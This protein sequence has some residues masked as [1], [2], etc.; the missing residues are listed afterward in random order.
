MHVTEPQSVAQPVLP[1]VYFTAHVRTRDV[2]YLSSHPSLVNHYYQY[3]HVY[4][5]ASYA[6]EHEVAF[7]DYP[8]KLVFD[9]NAS[10]VGERS[11]AGFVASPNS[12]VSQLYPA[13]FTEFGNDS[14]TV[15]TDIPLHVSS[16]FWNGTFLIGGASIKYTYPDG[17]VSKRHPTLSAIAIY[18]T[19]VLT[20]G[21]DN[22]LNLTASVPLQRPFSLSSIPSFKN[23]PSSNMT[24]PTPIRQWDERNIA[25]ASPRNIA[26]PVI[27]KLSSASFDNFS[28]VTAQGLVLSGTVTSVELDMCVLLID[29]ASSDEDVKN[30]AS[31]VFQLGKSI[32]DLSKAYAR[33]TG[34]SEGG[35]EF[36]C[37]NT[38][39]GDVMRAIQG[40][41][42]IIHFVSP[43]ASTWESLTAQVRGF[44]SDVVQVGSDAFATILGAIECASDLAMFPIPLPYP[45]CIGDLVMLGKDAYDVGKLVKD[46]RTLN[47]NFPDPVYSDGLFRGKWTNSWDEL[48]SFTMDVSTQDFYDV[49]GMLLREL[50]VCRDVKNQEILVY[51][52]PCIFANSVK[53]AYSITSDTRL[54]GQICAMAK[55]AGLYPILGNDALSNHKQTSSADL[56]DTYVAQAYMSMFPNRYPWKFALSCNARNSSSQS[57]TLGTQ[58]NSTLSNTM[59]PNGQTISGHDIPGLPTTSFPYTKYQ[60]IASN[61]RLSQPSQTWLRKTSRV[62]IKAHNNYSLS[63]LPQGYTTSTSASEFAVIFESSPHG[64]CGM[65]GALS[66]ALSITSP[67][68]DRQSLGYVLTGTTCFGSGVC[69]TTY[70]GTALLCIQNSSATSYHLFLVDKSYSDKPFYLSLKPDGAYLD[71]N[72]DEGD[73]SMRFYTTENIY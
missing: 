18:E 61:N 14:F 27:M 70:G 36:D 30:F 44:I 34:E 13:V 6:V 38:L 25:I 32:S 56:R 55:C 65:I 7:E 11:F 20:R 35:L 29:D 43:S 48:W 24:W 67:Q 49:D 39:H 57:V 37:A 21:M 71:P 46:A 28:N 52:M 4:R 2:E 58:T 17:R 5:V 51:A 40:S 15:H 3:P 73:P 66:N 22:S 60:C 47:F 42:D 9:F 16:Q 64:V 62:Y 26:D 10:K 23:V 33:C 45:A 41:E 72:L 31:A 1:S 69:V 12:V 68:D 19:C 63:A 53:R 8:G 54:T 59:I 50:L